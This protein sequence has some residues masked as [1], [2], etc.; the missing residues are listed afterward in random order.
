MLRRGVSDR[1]FISVLITGYQR[2]QFM[3]S[4]VDSLFR[5][6]DANFEVVVLK[7]WEDAVYDPYLRE[8]G[9]R[10]YNE[11]TWGHGRT[12]A[13]G[14]QRCEGEVVAILED[15]DEF[16]PTKLAVV[17]SMF[18]AH[19]D[20]VF[21]RNGFTEVPGPGV[22]PQPVSDFAFDTYDLHGV[23][24]RRAI[25]EHAYGCLSTFS[26][27]KDAVLPRLDDL[28]STMVAPDGVLAT[29][30]LDVR[31]RHHFSPERLTVRRTGTS[32]RP[33]GRAWDMEQARRVYER[34]AP[35]ATSPA[36]RMYVSSSL[37]WAKVESALSSSGTKLTVHDLVD[38]LRFFGFGF[39]ANRL[40]ITAWSLM[41]VLAP[42]LAIRGYARRRDSW[43]K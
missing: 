33:K 11:D 32:I 21:Y 23:G 22:I 36:A 34:L 12:L 13:R 1:P 29:I 18:G 25:R 26:F 38:Y 5:Q 40:E 16:L 17:A 39:D 35:K 31:G 14:I 41:D 2:R 30:L 10:L 28:E 7:D 37:A 3:R 4:A 20:L 27:R 9:V 43:A 8:H 6:Q 42:D 15:D 19:E 24:I